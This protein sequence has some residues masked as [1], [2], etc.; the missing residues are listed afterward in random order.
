[1]KL[2]RIQVGAVLRSRRWPK[3]VDNTMELYTFPLAR[4]L[5]IGRGR[6][7]VEAKIVVRLRGADS[8]LINNTTEFYTL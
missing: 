8:S 2:L 6:G 1:M 4:V 7:L 5:A 3:L